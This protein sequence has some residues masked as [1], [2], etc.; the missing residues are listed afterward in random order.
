MS[1][2]EPSEILG[3]EPDESTRIAPVPVTVEGPVRVQQMPAV[4]GYMRTINITDVPEQI[5]GVNPRRSRL[6][7]R[8]TAIA[9]ADGDKINVANTAGEAAA[10]TGFILAS[11]AWGSNMSTELFHQG[12]VWAALTPATGVASMPLSMIIEEWTE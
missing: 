11:D 4:N 7:L 12:E 5:A 6:V 2:P 3:I 10:G 8:N 1:N 9:P